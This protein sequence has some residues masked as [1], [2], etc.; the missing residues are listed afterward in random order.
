LRPGGTDCRLAPRKRQHQAEATTWAQ[1][2]RPSAG[3]TPAL[4][5]WAGS[6][7]AGP[8]ADLPAVAQALDG[9]LIARG[10]DGEREISS[11]DVFVDC[12][13]TSRLPGEI[14]TAIRIPELRPGG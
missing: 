4:A 11:A 8:A 2:R 12:L 14:L 6:S 13:T 3:L 10:P 9:V 1:P 5:R 7:H